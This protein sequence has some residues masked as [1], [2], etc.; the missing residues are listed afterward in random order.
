V[1]EG[2][3]QMNPDEFISACDADEQRSQHA[4]RFLSGRDLLH[5]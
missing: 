3:K 4:C 2:G 5:G 1:Q